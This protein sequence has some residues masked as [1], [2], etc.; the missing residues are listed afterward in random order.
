MVLLAVLLVALAG[1]ATWL[2][3]SFD[4]ERVKRSTIDWMQAEHGRELVIEGPLTLRLWP[5]PAVTVQGVRLSEPGQ[6]GQRFATIE[7][8]SL[9]LRLEPLL[10]RREIAVD[11]IT[12][13]GVKLRLRRA[14]EEARQHAL[15]AS[16][17]RNRSGSMPPCTT[18]IRR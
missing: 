14:L 11:R 7:E 2:L 6:P 9:T 16:A 15:A 5:Q 4:G 8:A 13:H 17:G 10:A 12:A 1:L 3:R 18:R